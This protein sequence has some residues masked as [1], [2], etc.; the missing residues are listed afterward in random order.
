V[1]SLATGAISLR[2]LQL[3]VSELRNRPQAAT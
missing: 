2:K 3:T 1:L